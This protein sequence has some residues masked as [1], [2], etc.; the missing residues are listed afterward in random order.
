MIVPLSS[1]VSVLSLSQRLSLVVLL[2]I[3]AATRCWS[4]NPQDGIQ[5][6][7]S[8][9][10]EWKYALVG[11]PRRMPETGH[12]FGV[13]RQATGGIDGVFGLRRRSAGDM[14][15]RTLEQRV[16]L[17]SLSPAD[18][19]PLFDRQ[20]L[21]APYLATLTTRDEHV[22][23][24]ENWPGVSFSIGATDNNVMPRKIAGDAT[25]WVWTDASPEG[26]SGVAARVGTGASWDGWGQSPVQPPNNDPVQESYA[27]V[28]C[29]FGG[30]WKAEEF[31]PQTFALI[32]WGQ[33][34]VLPNATGQPLPA[35]GWNPPALPCFRG[36]RY[37]AF[38]VQGSWEQ[39]RDW[40]VA[41]GGHLAVPTSNDEFLFLLSILNAVPSG[42]YFVGSSD[43]NSTGLYV[44]N[45]SAPEDGLLVY[46]D[47][48]TSGNFSLWNP[49]EPNGV[50]E[51]HTELVRC[52]GWNDID[53]SAAS[54]GY[55]VEFEND[56][57]CVPPTTGLGTTGLATTG[58]A[59]TGPSAATP[60]VAG[61]SSQASNDNLGLILGLVFGILFCCCLVVALV[62]FA[63]RRRSRDEIMF[64]HDASPDAEYHNR[65][66]LGGT[67][68]ASD[69][70]KRD[71]VESTLSLPLTP[72]LQQPYPTL[73]SG[74]R[75]IPEVASAVDANYNTA[76]SAQVVDGAAQ[77]SGTEFL[78]SDV[79][80]LSTSAL[81]GTGA[82][83]VVYSAV[84]ARPINGV[85][86]G[87]RVAI[88]ELNSATVDESELAAF[89]REA[90]TMRS[91]PPHE[92][93][94]Q[95][96]GVTREPLTIAVLL[97]ENG[98]LCQY[99]KSHKGDIP[100]SQ[101]W[102]WALQIARRMELLAEHGI[103]HREYVFVT[104]SL[105]LCPYAD[106]SRNSLATRNVL[107]DAQLQA[108]VSEYVP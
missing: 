95:L 90:D 49:Y 66:Q 35:S 10:N 36:N 70:P 32:E 13:V 62:L 24:V 20:V 39:T 12:W 46:N 33:T 45:V 31:W 81:L 94:V 57:T 102:Y 43:E 7:N 41:Q 22:F 55:I 52:V 17:F 86:V 11:P 79:F 16:P 30:R 18:T 56:P 28:E 9:T 64:G 40:A 25:D 71:Y 97:M 91:L 27:R 3:S 53:G 101:K 44:V 14:M 37:Q 54:R 15:W 96:I 42:S 4:W 34:P 67:T 21:G 6:G 63:R 61:D 59:T 105:L 2:S 74:W 98:D 19:P 93:V 65:A 23:V 47:S 106:S 69:P 8:G 50:T 80:N 78:P 75:D 85:E 83:G 104:L 88:K 58:L 1:S 51:R 92:N 107:L 76:F 100:I 84:V 77:D 68:M 87:T 29:G 72:G 89:M 99:I 82:F 73:R 38:A 60:E 108:A 5:V 103:V 48:L 26:P